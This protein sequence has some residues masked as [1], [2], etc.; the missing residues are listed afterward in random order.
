MKIL[1]IQVSAKYKHKPDEAIKLLAHEVTHI[2]NEQE[3][4]NWLVRHW[5]DN[6]GRRR[7]VTRKDAEDYKNTNVT[8]MFN[9]VL[10]TMEAEGKHQKGLFPDGS[11][12]QRSWPET[13][14]E[15][16]TPG[17]KELLDWNSDD[18]FNLDLLW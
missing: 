4:V 17:P 1:W 18:R 3:R 9:K 2:A 12:E 13:G 5:N 7:F 8:E 11:A 14:P 16:N 10:A 6:P 15:F